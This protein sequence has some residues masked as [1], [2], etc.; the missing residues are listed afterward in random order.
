MSTTKSPNKIVTRSLP[1]IR[2]DAPAWK[3]RSNFLSTSGGAQKALP[4]SNSRTFPKSNCTSS[5]GNLE[6]LI[7]PSSEKATN[8]ISSVAD[9]P[10][11]TTVSRQ[12]FP[13]NGTTQERNS[14]LDAMTRASLLRICGPVAGSFWI[15]QLN[16]EDPLDP[17][18][19]LLHPQPSQPSPA[20]TD[21]SGRN[22]SARSPKRKP[23]SERPARSRRG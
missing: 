10:S 5:S 23:P 22:Y 3:Y 7:I 12:Y 16:L 14:F 2:A 17:M 20:R 1:S 11:D 18:P 6:K 9:S 4:I 21:E 15:K 8:R 19:D 13:T